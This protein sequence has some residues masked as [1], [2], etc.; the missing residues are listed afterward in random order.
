MVGISS[1][2]YRPST[3]TFAT[4]HSHTHTLRLNRYD[5]IT[6]KNK[7]WRYFDSFQCCDATAVIFKNSLTTRHH[8]PCES[9]LLLLLNWILRI[10]FVVII[11]FLHLYAFSFLCLLLC[12][13]FFFSSFF[14]N[15]KPTYVRLAS[16]YTE[17]KT[18]QRMLYTRM[19]DI[20]SFYIVYLIARVWTELR[21]IL[22][23]FYPLFD[24]FHTRTKMYIQLL[25]PLPLFKKQWTAVKQME[26]VGMSRV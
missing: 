10:Q 20:H 4:T 9:L 23:F 25:S 14:F 3:I 8:M 18:W 19:W 21:R 22:F 26:T 1:T 12:F 15:L 11:W 24:F 5:F 13:F 2:V 6:H 7:Q 17:K 16:E